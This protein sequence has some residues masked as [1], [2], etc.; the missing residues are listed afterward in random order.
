MILAS[1]YNFVIFP[2]NVSA[3]FE[4]LEKKYSFIVLVGNSAL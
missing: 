1:K 2:K 3:D 4:S